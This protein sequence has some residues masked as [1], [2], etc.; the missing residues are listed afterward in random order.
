MRPRWFG[1]SRVIILIILLA[2][3]VSDA[4][5]PY[6]RGCQCLRTS[7]VALLVFYKVSTESLYEDRELRWPGDVPVLP[8]WGSYVL[9]IT[10]CAIW[11]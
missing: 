3:V 6:M 4:D 9:T 1:P 2:V 7:T 11:D 5:L 10:G 8:S